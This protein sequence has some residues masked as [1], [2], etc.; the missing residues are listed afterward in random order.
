MY[1]ARIEHSGMYDHKAQFSGAGPV[2]LKRGAPLHILV[3]FVLLWP[4]PAL[5]ACNAWIKEPV[6]EGF[7]A[8]QLLAFKP[9]PWI[10]RKGSAFK[11]KDLARKKRLHM[12]RLINPALRVLGCPK[13]TLEDSLTLGHGGYVI[14]G[15][16][17]C[18]KN[19]KGPDILIHE[20]RSDMNMNESFNIYVTP[21]RAG[22]GP[23]YNV[24]KNVTVSSAN[25]FLELELTGI[26]DAHG[27]PVDEF[28]WIKIEDAN[29][30]VVLS[31][32]RY[33]GFDIS[34]VKF[35]HSCNVP[36]G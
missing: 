33:A 12:H 28:S 4:A 23:W 10:E 8:S 36:V 7:Y 15:P 29:S 9:G 13:L 6:K 1:S 21:D 11:G 16:S 30:R 14:V 17:D 3:I 27:H 32:A 34:A 22:K 19:G 24:A 35:I 20:P 2:A 26:I 25:N 18:F 31:H 5:A